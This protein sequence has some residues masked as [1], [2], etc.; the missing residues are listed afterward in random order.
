MYAGATEITPMLPAG[1]SIGTNTAPW[2]VAA[3]GSLICEI[4]AEID[5]AVA[6][7]GYGVP[8]SST[9]TVA[10]ARLQYLCKQGVCWQVLKPIFPDMGGPGDKVTLAGEYRKAYQDGLAAI[11]AGQEAL[12]GASSNTSDAGRVLP[13]SKSSSNLGSSIAS[14][15]SLNWE[16]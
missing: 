4:S 12:I 13:R 14:G 1:V 3:V 8:V 11:R 16:P 7:A 6:G 2:T 5:S 9:A 10:Y 15:F